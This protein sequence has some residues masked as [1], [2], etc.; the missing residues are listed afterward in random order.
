[1]PGKRFLPRKEKVAASGNAR[2]ARE[3]EVPV[4]R[5]RLCSSFFR[6]RQDLHLRRRSTEA[7]N[8]GVRR[9]YTEGYRKS[10]VKDPLDRVNTKDNTPVVIHTEIVPRR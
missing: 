10:I 9:G 6:N 1:M 3:E 7:V 5:Y 8:E 4:S 2:I